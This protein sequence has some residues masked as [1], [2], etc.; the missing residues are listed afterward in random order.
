MAEKSFKVSVKKSYWGS[1]IFI[2][3]LS[4]GFFIFF[5][6]FLPDKLFPEKTKVDQEHRAVD[7]WMQSAMEE[8]QDSIVEEEIV[9]KS[10]TDIQKDTLSTEA[11]SIEEDQ[12][13]LVEADSLGSQNTDFLN[14]FYEAL[15]QLEQ[16]PESAKVRIAYF[17]DSMTDGDLI[18]QDIRRKYQEKYGGRGVGFVPVVSESANSR[19]SITHRF[20]N[21]WK[22]FT[23]MKKYENPPPFGIS[24]TVFYAD[25]SLQPS[26][27]RFGAGV[28]ATNHLLPNP[29]L[30]YGIS[31]NNSAEV[32][33]I[34]IKDTL[35]YQLQPVKKLNKLKLSSATLSKMEL[36]F[37]RADSIPV[38]GVNF[39]ND[40]G[41]QIDNFSNRGNSGLPLTQLDAELM[42]A[43]QQELQYNL[44]VLQF[45]TNVLNSDS[46]KYGWYQARMK[47][48]VSYLRKIFPEAAI[49]V[50]SIADKATKYDTEMQTDSAVNYLLSA[51]KAYAKE[52]KTGF[53]NLFSLMGGEGS[54]IKW[55]EEEP[56]KAN[57]DYT[58]FNHIGARKIAEMIFK[59]LESGFEEFKIQ[60]EK[61]E[62]KAQKE[63]EQILKLLDEIEIQKPDSSDVEIP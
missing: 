45:G 41:V 34:T 37:K 27:L 14:L 53:V 24:G 1:A 55:V 40:F 35:H 13:K 28:N 8:P 57:K 18:V 15:F 16:N 42:K 26:Q 20:S 9:D 39:D 17:G 47:R 32:E 51:Q 23:F 11:V 30:F 56:Q 43:F 6:N 62:K 2:L 36:N 33:M 5:K 21:N 58:H 7:E 4:I 48:V 3:L 19:A 31:S 38:Y 59:E 63:R 22:T 52:E 44:I 10:E 29:V 12:S 25:D 50:V 60:K 46:F 61:S 54:M 49:L